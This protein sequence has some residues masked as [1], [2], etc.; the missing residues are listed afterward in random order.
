MHTKD[1]SFLTPIADVEVRRALVVA[2]REVI[3]YKI[4]YVAPAYQLATQNYYTWIRGKVNSLSEERQ[5]RVME[6][7]G[8]HPSG[9]LIE[10]ALHAWEINGEEGAKAAQLMLSYETDIVDVCINPAYTNIRGRRRDPNEMVHCFIGV[11]VRWALPVPGGKLMPRRLIMAA[12]S[13]SWTEDSFM[14]WVKELFVS[15]IAKG[16]KIEIGDDVTVVQDTAESIWRWHSKPREADGSRA[17]NPP[18]KGLLAFDQDII[19]KSKPA[20]ESA[21]SVLEDMT[22]RFKRLAEAVAD[23]RGT[24]VSS[25]DLSIM[26]RA[27]AVIQ[28]TAAEAK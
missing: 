5:H 25:V 24:S 19:G 27:N 11:S 3:K 9:R 16:Q 7:Y 18:N 21:L 10:S 14:D 8:F 13:G 12:S 1:E 22:P 28:A 26:R 4:S 23:Q 20:R 2:G 6:M 15:R 17:K